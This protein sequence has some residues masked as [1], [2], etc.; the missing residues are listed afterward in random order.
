MSSL[1]PRSGRTTVTYFTI[2]IFQFR[3]LSE[4]A[5]GPTLPSQHISIPPEIQTLSATA[6]ALRMFPRL[7]A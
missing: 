6:H 3:S 4:R 1:D 5:P 7:V 2:Q